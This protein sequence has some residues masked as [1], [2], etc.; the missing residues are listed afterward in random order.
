M[1]TLRLCELPAKFCTILNQLSWRS[2]FK[3]S[4][5]GTRSILGD[6][7]ALRVSQ[8]SQS[9]HPS[10]QIQWGFSTQPQ[11]VSAKARGSATTI[12]RNCRNVTQANSFS[13]RTAITRK[14]LRAWTDRYTR[15]DSDEAWE[16]DCWNTCHWSSHSNYLVNWR[17]STALS[18]V[19]IIYSKNNIHLCHVY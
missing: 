8:P 12:Q 17:I 18:Y 5:R 14:N 4:K 2:S 19:M 3:G 10:Q 11:A 6:G 15:A 1:T 16:Q 9:S 13:P 7:V